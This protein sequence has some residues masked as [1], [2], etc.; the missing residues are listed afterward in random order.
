MP[1]VCRRKAA[2]PSPYILL[3]HFLHQ[4]T[5]L[6]SIPCRDARVHMPDSEAAQAAA[7]GLWVDTYATQAKSNSHTITPPGYNPYTVWPSLNRGATPSC[8]RL[9]NYILYMFRVTNAD[10]RMTYA[11]F[12]ESEWQG[13]A[14]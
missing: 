1:L 11:V 12:E 3:H 8:A 6:G 14:K 4:G 2:H 9:C 13:N 5:A 7:G 10:I